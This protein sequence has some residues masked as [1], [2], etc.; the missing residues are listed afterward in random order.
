MYEFYF[1]VL[2]PLVVPKEALRDGEHVSALLFE[3]RTVVVEISIYPTGALN[4]Y[5]YFRHR[6]LQRRRRSYPY[7]SVRKS[8]TRAA[9]LEYQLV[10]RHQC[11][12]DAPYYYYFL[13]R[14]NFKPRWLSRI[15]YDSLF[16]S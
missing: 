13:G 6:D 4:Y 8:L 5:H 12:R 10:G 9:I 16:Y 1:L 11:H 7:G 2:P 15:Q 14:I 3:I